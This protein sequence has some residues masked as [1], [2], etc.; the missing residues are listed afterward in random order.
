MCI[1]IEKLQN[2]RKYGT[3]LLLNSDNF[4]IIER[5]R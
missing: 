3:E 2:K 4:K 1:S 5:D